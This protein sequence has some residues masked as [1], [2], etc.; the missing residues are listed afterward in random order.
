MIEGGYLVHYYSVG[1]RFAQRPRET[2]GEGLKHYG[3]L[4]RKTRH[5]PGG[6]AD[7][8]QT[9]ATIDKGVQLLTKGQSPD[10][11]TR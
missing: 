6:G 2:T 8:W 4:H 11:L 10:S 1:L 5:P 3:S 9:N 7:V